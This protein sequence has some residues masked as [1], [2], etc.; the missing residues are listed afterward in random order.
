MFIW[1][2]ISCW[3][4]GRCQRCHCKNKQMHHRYVSE[5]FLYT[6]RCFV[7]NIKTK[8]SQIETENRKRRTKIN[9][10]FIAYDLSLSMS[11]YIHQLLV[12]SFRSH[13]T[14]IRVFFG[15]IV[16]VGDVHNTNA[17]MNRTSNAFN[18]YTTVVSAVVA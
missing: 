13:T 10:I 14:H 7:L 2:Y 5:F 8:A 3:D 4:D 17:N 18:R 6:H 9:D 11:I 15:D 1:L 16:T 12:G